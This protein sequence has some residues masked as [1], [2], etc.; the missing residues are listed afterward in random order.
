M[1]LLLI[2]RQRTLRSV[3]NVKVYSIVER[4]ANL[5]TGHN[6][7]LNAKIKNLNHY[8]QMVL[9]QLT[10]D[11][12]NNS[13]ALSPVL[14]QKLNYLKMENWLRAAL[15]D[16]AIVTVRVLFLRDAPNVTKYSTVD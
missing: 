3:L 9:N 8:L 12:M 7:S 1:Y 10:I 15:K 2:T 11:I 4:H 6:I 14:Q 13:M 5:S 16:V